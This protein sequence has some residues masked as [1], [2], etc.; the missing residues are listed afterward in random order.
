MRNGKKIKGLDKTSEK[1]DYEQLKQRVDILEK[2]IAENVSKTEELKASFLRNLYHE[3]RTPMNA[4]LGFRS[5][6]ENYNLNSEEKEKYGEYLQKSSKEFLK[7]LDDIV[8]AALIDAGL[9]KLEIGECSID[10]MM[11]EI[12][13]FFT[14][15][16]HVLGKDHVVLLKK[17]AEEDKNI[18]IPTDKRRLSQILTYLLSNA[19]KFTEKGVIE[20]GYTYHQDRL[21]FFVIDSGIG[22][23]HHKMEDIFEPFIKLDNTAAGKKGLGLGLSSAKHLVELFGG[24]IWVEANRPRGSVFRFS[25]PVISQRSKQENRFEK[26]RIN[27]GKQYNNNRNFL[28]ILK[29]ETLGQYRFLF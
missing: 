11:D 14:V 29:M 21:E 16:K 1:S 22:G 8:E 17:I 19:F 28:K 20:Y 6:L 2:V 18:I 5:L 25:I 26:F 7:V 9:V 23:L 27:A 10:Q 13:S 15:Q 24:K 3:I 12:H 4:I